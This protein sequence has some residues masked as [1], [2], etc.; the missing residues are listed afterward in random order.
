MQQYDQD[1]RYGAAGAPLRTLSHPDFEQQLSVHPKVYELLMQRIGK[2]PKDIFEYLS[3][4]LKN[5]PKMTNLIDLEKASLRII[6]AI[7]NQEVIGVHGD[8]DVDGTT[9]L[10]LLYHFF[11]MLKV[12]IKL[13]QPSRFVEGYGV[14][15]SSVDQAKKA[16]ASILITVDCGITNVRTAE[17]AL[18]QGIDLIITDHHKDAAERIPPAYAV[19]NPNRRDENNSPLASLAG[20]GVAFSLALQIKEDLESQGDK[21]PSIYPLLQWVALGTICDLAHLG[22]TNLKLCRHGIKQFAETQYPGIQAFLTKDEIAQKSV[23]SDKL[24][25]N[26][27]PMINSKGRL[28][29]PGRALDLLTSHDIV[30]SIDIHQHLMNTN[31]ERK[32][33]QK[34]VF[35]EAKYL[36][37]KEYP[38]GPDAISIVYDPAWH[39]GVI[40][41]VASKL[42]ETFKVAAIVFTDAEQEGIIKASARGAGSVNL[43]NL[44]K[45][46]EHLFEKFGGHHKA[47]GLSM[48]KENL[49]A[50]KNALT[51]KLRVI[52]DEE[53]KEFK[54][55]DLRLS[56]K[57]VNFE[58]IQSLSLMEPFG[59]GN[60]KPLF[61]I[62]DIILEQYQILKDTHVK[63]IFGLKYSKTNIKKSINGISFFYLNQFNMIDPEKLIHEQSERNLYIDCTVGVNTFRNRRSLQLMVE[64]IGF[65]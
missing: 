46:Q 59:Q 15:P 8:Y 44:L 35:E 32:D 51:Q 49:A 64:S 25:F 23:P 57:D 26:M 39:E 7:A 50:L 43:F 1:Q 61:R 19:I 58:L 9:S 48:K 29:H 2:D 63:W 10:A 65:Q 22:P 13:F 38:T 41:I 20:V 33:I 42:V 40:G 60:P 54:E 17:Y 52:P 30:E 5:L 56:L 11:R 12:D 6:Q 47:A 14:H 21:L 37:L 4:D 18:E 16:G 28:D 45:E 53:K 62:D 31:Q 55:Y 36:V 27:G 24:A 3:W 34:K